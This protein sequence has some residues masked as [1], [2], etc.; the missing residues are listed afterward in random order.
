MIDGP[1]TTISRQFKIEIKILDYVIGI[2]LALFFDLHTTYCSILE[3]DR[4]V[5]GEI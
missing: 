2:V 1:E 5:P 4:K 3:T